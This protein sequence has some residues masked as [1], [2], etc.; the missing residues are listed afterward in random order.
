MIKEHSADI[1]AVIPARGGSKGIPKKNIRLL[2]GKPLV[3]YT[4]EAAIGSGAARDVLVSTD[5]EEIAAVSRN[6]GAKIIAR[7]AEISDDTASTE[8]ALIH[9]VE[10]IREERGFTPEYV[11]T[12]PPTSPLRNAGTIKIFLNHYLSISG[13]Y[14]AMLTLTETYGDYWVKENDMF[15]RLFPEAPRRRQDRRPVYLENSA[16]YITR[17]QSLLE[18]GSILGKN[19]TGFIISK[20]EAVDINSPLDLKWAEFILKT[21]IQN[22]D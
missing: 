5:S 14:D 12:L 9:A 21:S 13:R 10:V 7:P 2:N 1:I 22:R 17:T 6:F 4:I 19:C 3:A 8:A 11:L 15:K 18:T 16:I 20:T